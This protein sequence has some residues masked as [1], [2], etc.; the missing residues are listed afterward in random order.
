MSSE[1]PR[2]LESIPEFIASLSGRPEIRVVDE[3]SSWRMLVHPRA[4][5]PV[6][7]LVPRRVLEWYALVRGPDG[8]EAWQ[9][10]MDYVGYDASPVE[11]LRADM[12]RDLEEFVETV[13]RADELRVRTLGK[14]WPSGARA[15]EWRHDGTW[16]PVTL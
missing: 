9:D 6:E 4:G 3:G 12:V 2:N 13:V 10:W 16:S 11:R 5:L 8:E 14:G 7:V 15:I 1:R